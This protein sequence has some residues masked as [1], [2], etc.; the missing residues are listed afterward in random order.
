MTRALPLAALLASL[1]STPARAA[2]PEPRRAEAQERFDRGLPLLEKTG[3]PPGARA[4]FGRAY[5]LAPP[6]R[7][8]FLSGPAPSW[9]PARA[10]S[11]R[12]RKRRWPAG[13]RC[14]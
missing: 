6:T 14:L 8:W 5:G 11:P 3:D 9:P 1:L 12:A 7:T 13:R 4:R 2:P 10:T